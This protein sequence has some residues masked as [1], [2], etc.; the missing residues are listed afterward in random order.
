MMAPERR[1][2][3]LVWDED[4]ILYPAAVFQ[5]EQDAENA[6][7]A[8]ADRFLAKALEEPRDLEAGDLPYDEA[9]IRAYFADHLSVERW[10]SLPLF[11][12]DEYGQSERD[13]ERVYGELEDYIDGTEE[14]ENARYYG[15]VQEAS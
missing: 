4:E 3:T 10:S 1:A 12:T 13:V 11:L 14:I 2:W 15:T 6:K 5:S 9:K 7:A 8:L